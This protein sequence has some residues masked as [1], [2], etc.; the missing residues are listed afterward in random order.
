MPAVPPI[1]CHVLDT[2][3]GRPATEVK[4]EISYISG[5]T[6]A[7]QPFATAETNSDGRVPSWT[8]IK[9][10]ISTQFFETNGEDWIK[11]TAGVYKIR[12]FTKEYFQRAREPGSSLTFFP[13][14]DIN[15]EVADDSTSQ[16]FHVPLLL[17]NYGYS[18]YRGS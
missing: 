2:T 4:C 5:T 14:I 16:H 17:S 1:T 7:E 6:N 8:P 10:T 12:F 15:F 11:L 9:G 18:T 3:K 13:F